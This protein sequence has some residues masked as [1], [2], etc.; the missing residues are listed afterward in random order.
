MKYSVAV[1]AAEGGRASWRTTAWERDRRRQLVRQL[2]CAVESSA[3]LAVRLGVSA[4]T[5][6]R[7]KRRNQSE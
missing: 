4:R 5:I 3:E 1:H 2:S 7:D 6:E